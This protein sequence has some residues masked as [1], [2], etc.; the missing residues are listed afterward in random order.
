MDK[1][2]YL[3]ARRNSCVIL[4]TE[5]TVKNNYF[6]DILHAIYHDKLNKIL[7]V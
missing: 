3:Q 2:F 6:N 7:R 1:T 4:R 5:S